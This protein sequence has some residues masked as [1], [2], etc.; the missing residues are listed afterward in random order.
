MSE[1]CFGHKRTQDLSRSAVDLTETLIV[2]YTG[3]EYAYCIPNPYATLVCGKRT[4]RKVKCDCGLNHC[5]N[6]L[7]M[8]RKTHVSGPR[9][10]ALGDVPNSE[11][12]APELPVWTS[13]RRSRVGT[14]RCV[15]VLGPAGKSSTLREASAV[16]GR[17]CSPRN[18]E[19]LWGVYSCRRFNQTCFS[20]VF[21]FNFSW[22]F[23]SV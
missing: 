13:A 16:R 6:F 4:R 10:N 17:F 11:Q 15:E 23:F 14:E 2:Y 7:S 20:L 3:E 19:M 12:P 8:H 9:A 22:V 5:S 18:I 21:A 1:T